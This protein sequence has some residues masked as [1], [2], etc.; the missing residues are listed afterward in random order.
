MPMSSPGVLSLLRAIDAYS[1]T[2]VAYDIS[3]GWSF[4]KRAPG[5]RPSRDIPETRHH[6]A[7]RY[8]PETLAHAAPECCG[9][10]YLRGDRPPSPLDYTEAFRGRG[11]WP[12]QCSW[13]MTKVR[14]FDPS[15]AEDFRKPRPLTCRSSSRTAPH[16]CAAV[17]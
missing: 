13:T 10:S 1:F 9:R 3:D 17:P 7:R 2:L 11:H 8:R 15:A 14:D 16:S 5:T 6:A 12:V 4:S